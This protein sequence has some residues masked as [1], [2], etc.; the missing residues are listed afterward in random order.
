MACS[1][2]SRRSPR[3]IDTNGTPGRCPRGGH[4][5]E[6]LTLNPLSIYIS[7]WRH[8][9]Q[10]ASLHGATPSGGIVHK[11]TVARPELEGF[12][13][14]GHLPQEASPAGGPMA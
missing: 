9:L 6:G 3:P 12:P 4:I 5:R 13:R 11:R 8:P 2:C 1:A 14:S 10:G 7:L